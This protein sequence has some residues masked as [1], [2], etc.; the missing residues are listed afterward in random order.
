VQFKAFSVLP[1]EFAPYP[2]M[3]SSSHSWEQPERK[4]PRWDR[5]PDDGDDGG[6][7]GGEC[8]DSDSDGDEEPPTAG[9]LLVKHLLNLFMCNKIG[10]ADTTKAMWFAKEAGIAEAKPFSLKPGSNAG[11]CSRKLKIALGHANSPDIYELPTP[12]HAKHDL[13]R[14]VHNIS[15]LPAHEQLNEDLEND[16]SCRAKLAEL[17]RDRAFPPC[18]WAHPIVQRYEAEGTPVLPTAVYIDAVPYSQVDSVLGFWLVNLVSGRRYC[19]G[20][21]RKSEVCKCGCRGWCSFYGFF[22]YIVWSLTAMANACFPDCRHDQTK[23]RP[24]DQKRVGLSGKPM[25][26]PG[27]CLYMKGDWS[28]YST[29]LGLPNWQDGFRPCFCCNASGNLY[30]ATG[31]DENASR[32]LENVEGDYEAACARCSITV[33]VADEAARDMIAN[34]LRYDKRSGG[35]RGR[36]LTQSIPAL[37]LEQHD[38]LEPSD[39]LWDIGAFEEIP[40]PA[41][42]I[43]WRPSRESLARHRNPLM[44]SALG[45]EP[46]RA[47]TVDVLHA[48]HLGVLKIWCRIAVWMVLESGIY[49]SLGTAEENLQVAVLAF[50]AALM[51]WYKRRHSEFPKERLTR[52]ADFTVK[53]IGSK[54]DPALKTKGAETYGFTKFLVFLFETYTDRF[55]PE[56]RRVLAAGKALDDIISIWKKHSDSWTIP[57]ADRKDCAMGFLLPDS[58]TLPLCCDNCN[59]YLI[60]FA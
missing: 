48:L 50:R 10:A 13:S 4:R 46:S 18:Y 58:N 31:N 17:Y 1:I 60:A 49:G 47:L 19:F 24:S 2:I 33:N 29:T 5:D 59:T 28:E 6:Y 53:M 42:V 21:F 25:V 26:L 44:V 7:W 3:A 12:G 8:S 51:A 35:S 37:N 14:T 38:R 36:A 40:V 22:K 34:K 56:S 15:S 52:V 54:S 41:I 30:V 23:W 43:F 45:M 55:G 16:V 20:I 27:C 57:A 39:G 32:W 9:G 11:H